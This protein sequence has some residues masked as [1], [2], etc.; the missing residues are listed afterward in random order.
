LLEYNLSERCIASRLAM[1]SQFN[2][3]YGALIECETR[4]GRK[5][6]MWISDWFAPDRS[7]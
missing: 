6:T 7:E 5:P 3:R 2:Y 4:E 1:R